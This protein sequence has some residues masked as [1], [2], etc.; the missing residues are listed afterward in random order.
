MGDLP[1]TKSICF[2]MSLVP[3]QVLAEAAA[4]V[5]FLFN[6]FARWWFQN[7]VLFS[8]LPGEMIRFD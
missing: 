3:E 7:F 4:D 8:P 5:V 2:Y 1:G 6:I